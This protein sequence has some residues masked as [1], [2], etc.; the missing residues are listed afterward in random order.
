MVTGSIL[1]G[2]SCVV[3]CVMM[4]AMCVDRESVVPTVKQALVKWESQH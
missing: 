2:L 4:C 1:P 3:S